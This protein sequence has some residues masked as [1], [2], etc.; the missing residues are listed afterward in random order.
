VGTDRVDLANVHHAFPLLLREVALH[1]L[2]LYEA[3]PGAFAGLQLAALGRYMDT[4]RFRR[5]RSE[6]LRSAAQP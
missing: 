1:G 6:L 2:P 4:S 5:L 3:T